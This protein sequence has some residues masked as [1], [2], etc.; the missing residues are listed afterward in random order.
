MEKIAQ[1]IAS[2]YKN[3]SLKSQFLSKLQQISKKYHLSLKKKINQQNSKWDQKDAVLITYGDIIEKP[4]EETIKTFEKF[5]INKKINHFFSTVH[6]LPF[7]PWTSDDGFSIIDYR[8]INPKISSNWENLLELSKKINLCFDL[9]L[10]HCSSKNQWF[11]DFLNEKK[12]VEN[13][14]HVFSPQEIEKIDFS[15]VVRPRQSPLLTEFKTISGD[16]KLIWTTF[17]DDQV[18]LNFNSPNVLFEFL[19]LLIFF[20]IKGARI[21]RLDAIAYIWKEI[22]TKSI[23]LPQVHQIV[24]IMRDL[25][26]LFEETKNAIILTETNVPHQENISYL[27]ITEN[28]EQHYKEAHMCYQFPLPP[29]LLYSLLNENVEQIVKWINSLNQIKIPNDCT[30]LNFT[31]SHDGIG[32]RPLEGIIPQKELEKLIKHVE[33][34]GGKVSFKKNSDGSISPYELNIVYLD[35]LSSS[36]IFQLDPNQKKLENNISR[37]ILSQAFTMSLKG[38]PAIYF[39]S[40]VGT[41]NDFEKFQKEKYNRALNRHTYSEKEIENQLNDP[42]SENS[43]IFNQLSNLLQI[44]RNCPAF[45][46]N[47]NQFFPQYPNSIQKELI[48]FIRQAYD[49]SGILI[50]LANFSSKP[51]VFQFNSI[52]NWEEWEKIKNQSKK[53]T[54]F[55]LI[56]KNTFD[57]SNSINLNPFQIFWLWNENK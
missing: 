25:V 23:H 49:L 50:V 32:V 19:D 41:R 16:K 48:V 54:F 33:S 53:F 56:S 36:S 47:S 21:I 45:H 28:G 44:R 40:L 4:E 34:L 42:N 12:E 39:H 52:S 43:R 2:L 27:G 11:I 18:D 46:P 5:L 8:R 10:N 38:I 6:I 31:A 14:F 29:L 15:S 22:G 13:F 55:D 30:F 57:L 37:F 26:D 3:N 51:Q 17:S 7:F 20:I 9:V 24:Q 1:K 35:A